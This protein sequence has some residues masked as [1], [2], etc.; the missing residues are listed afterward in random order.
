MGGNQKQAQKEDNIVSFSGPQPEHLG[1]PSVAASPQLPLTLCTH[2][3]RVLE[4]SGVWQ[5]LLFSFTVF[6]FSPKSALLESSDSNVAADFCL[7][8]CSQ[9][10]GFLLLWAD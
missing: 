5:V 3:V 6:L 1:L 8:F 7:N 2:T 10:T 4:H 9:L